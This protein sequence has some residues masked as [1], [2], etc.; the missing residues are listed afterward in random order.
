MN[1]RLSRLLPWLIPLAGA[2]AL[3]FLVGCPLR[4]LLGIG[5]PLCGMS[6]ALLSAAQLA[7]AEA[8]RFHPLWPAVIPVSA[9]AVWMERRRPGSAKGL[10]IAVLVL[11]LAVYAIRLWL[12]DPIVWPDGS[13]GLLSLRV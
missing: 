4:Q 12:H 5:C 7:F 2:A 10:G 13:T 6:R 11:A 1:R 9:A 3:S 8:F